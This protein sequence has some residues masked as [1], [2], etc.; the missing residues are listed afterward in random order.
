MRVQAVDTEQVRKQRQRLLCQRSKLSRL[1]ESARE[2]A[3]SVAMYWDQICTK[4]SS[5]R[6]HKN[7]SLHPDGKAKHFTT[8]SQSASASETSRRSCV[9]SATHKYLLHLVS[10]HLK[11]N[12]T[13]SGSSAR[14]NVARER[15]L[16]A[17]RVAFLRRDHDKVARVEVFA[18]FF[19]AAVVDLTE[20]SRPVRERSCKEDRFEV[21]KRFERVE[22]VVWMRRLEA[23]VLEARDLRRRRVC[24]ERFVVGDQQRRTRLESSSLDHFD[25]PIKVVGLEIDLYQ[26]QLVEKVLGAAR[27]PVARQ[28][29]RLE[30]RQTLAGQKL[31]FEAA[32]GRVLR[33]LLQSAD[34][35]VSKGELDVLE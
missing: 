34:V 4:R 12:P 33:F 5:E 23:D 14:A 2:A 8:S 9:P 31:L 17:V 24:E 32:P 22:D 13:P 19:L 11:R 18:D 10:Y 25:R 7:P 30:V 28:A 26:P 35:K 6:L 16:D 15:R 3:G 1:S 29:E 20:A 21:G 27:Q